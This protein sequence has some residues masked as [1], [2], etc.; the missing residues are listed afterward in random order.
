[1]TNTTRPSR[2][3]LIDGLYQSGGRYA[4]I[5][6][7]YNGYGS[8]STDVARM[9]IKN[10]HL[11]ATGHFYALENPV[12]IH[13]LKMLGKQYIGIDSRWNFPHKVYIKNFIAS[14]LY[15]TFSE[16]DIRIH[17]SCLLY[18]SDAADE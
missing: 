9:T 15:S 7:E 4:G 11:Y 17:N 2:G 5:Q 8:T 1:M 14:G 13:D 3:M 10:M 16:L 18:T 6:S 12:Y